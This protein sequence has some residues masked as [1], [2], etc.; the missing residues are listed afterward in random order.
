VV[1]KPDDVPDPGASHEDRDR[2]VETLRVAGGDGRLTTEELDARLGR[3]FSARTLGEL[4][5]LTA[6]LPGT[7]A[8]RDVLVVGQYGSKYVKEGRWRTWCTASCS[9]S[10]RRAP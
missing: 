8:A 6:G 5:E 3:A 10:A 7:P 1:A 2:V 4:A 9:L